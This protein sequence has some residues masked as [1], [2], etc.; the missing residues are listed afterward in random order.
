MSLQ[1]LNDYL[2]EHHKAEIATTTLWRAL[3]RWGFTYGTGKRR[4]ALRERDDVILARREY[5]RVKRANRNPDG[6]LK[7]SE[8][9]LDETYINT[10]TAI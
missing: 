10:I 2:S 9:Y 8:V 6:T 5:L 3:Q 7:R 1:K 4:T